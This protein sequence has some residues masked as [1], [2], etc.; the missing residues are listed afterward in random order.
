MWLDLTVSCVS[1]RSSLVINR[2]GS[3]TVIPFDTARLLVVVQMNRTNPVFARSYGASILRAHLLD[4]ILKN[5]IEVDLDNYIRIGSPYD[6][7]VRSVRP[8]RVYSKLLASALCTT[9][10]LP[11]SHVHEFFLPSRSADATVFGLLAHCERG[12]RG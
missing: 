9:T 4:R 7:E 2:F 10:R 12:F 3:Q 1:S 6:G 8:A 5:A 11:F